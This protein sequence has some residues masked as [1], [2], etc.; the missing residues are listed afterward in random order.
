MVSELIFFIDPTG[1]KEFKRRSVRLGRPC[2][3]EWMFVRYIH[4]LRLLPSATSLHPRLQSPAPSGPINVL[5]PKGR[6]R[7]TKLNGIRIR[8]RF[9]KQFKLG[10]FKLVTE[11]GYAVAEAL[12]RL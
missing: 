1:A 10:A 6:N 5:S 8:R 9:S 7:R 12:R 4:G 11:P 2:R 3:G